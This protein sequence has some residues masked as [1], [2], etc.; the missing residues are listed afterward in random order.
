MTFYAMPASMFFSEHQ[1]LEPTLFSI[2]FKAIFN[3]V[4]THNESCFNDIYPGW[5]NE[6]IMTLTIVTT[7]RKTR[8]YLLQSARKT[9]ART[10]CWASAALP[11]RSSD[12]QQPTSRVSEGDVWGTPMWADLCRIHADRAILLCSPRLLPCLRAGWRRNCSRLPWLREEV[13]EG[14][15]VA[16]GRTASCFSSGEQ[17]SF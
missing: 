3:P 16:G 9:L 6:N 15:I 5:E 10:Q 2:K 1:S 11:A 4:C 17:A 12:T 7:R 14:E 13:L 8:P